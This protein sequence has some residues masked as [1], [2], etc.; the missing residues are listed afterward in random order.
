M[1]SNSKIFQQLQ[2][3]AR[4]EQL[5]HVNDLQ[6][7]LVPVYMPSHWGLIFIDLTNQELCFDDGLA[8]AAP[9]T[10]LPFAKHSLELL[11]EMYT[12]HPALQTRFWQNCSLFKHSGMPFQALIDSKMIGVGS[13]GI[14][15]IMAA[16]DFIKY[17]PFSITHFHW[18]YSQMYLHRKQLMLQILNW[19]KQH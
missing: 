15:A 9:P 10:A 1:N 11:L 6:H 2:L 8:S 12:Y 7:I 3:S 18:H 5:T 17:E 14:G 4:V 13:C 16:K 19:T